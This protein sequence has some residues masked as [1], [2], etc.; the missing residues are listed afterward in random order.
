MLADWADRREPRGSHGI[1]ISEA[2]DPEFQYDWEV[3]LP[4]MD[5]ALAKLR[6]EQERYKKTYPDADPSALLWRVK[7]S[8]ATE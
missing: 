3:D 8:G 5:F 6:A 1:R 4:T 7:R 2:T